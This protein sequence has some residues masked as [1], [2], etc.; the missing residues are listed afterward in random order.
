MSSK[1]IPEQRGAKSGSDEEC[2]FLKHG[3]RSVRGRIPK[4]V[5]VGRR[6]NE[7][8][9][10]PAPPDAGPAPGERALADRIYPTRPAPAG[11]SG[12]GQGPSLRE[13]QNVDG[14]GSMKLR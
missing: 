5:A 12:E 6:P 3:T 7:R 8:P 13:A 11:A 4:P 9:A 14:G 10:S 2:V 1:T